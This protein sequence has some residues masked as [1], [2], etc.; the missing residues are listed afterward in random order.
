MSTLLD[1]QTAEGFKRFSNTLHRVAKG[2]G[3][4]LSLQAFQHEIAKAVGAR[5]LEAYQAQIQESSA[6]QTKPWKPFVC[7]PYIIVKQEA[8]KAD[9]FLTTESLNSFVSGVSS[10][11]RLFSK[12]GA[13]DYVAKRKRQLESNIG[14]D[15]GLDNVAYTVK[16]LK[17]VFPVFYDFLNASTT[18]HID[19]LLSELTNAGFD[20]AFLERSDWKEEIDQGDSVLGYSEWLLHQLE[21]CRDEFHQMLHDNS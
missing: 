15:V 2:S 11:L 14:C 5:S 7:E 17:E 6:A 19:E 16:P 10:D 8:S 13:S 3:C 1:I 21:C 9:M 20:V 12:A 18:K 4:T